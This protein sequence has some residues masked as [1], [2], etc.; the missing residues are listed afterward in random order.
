MIAPLIGKKRSRKLAGAPSLVF[1]TQTIDVVYTGSL[2]MDAYAPPRLSHTTI[3]HI[4]GGGWTS[5][6]STGLGQTKATPANR[7]IVYSL[8]QHG[9]CVFD[10]DYTLVPT[11]T[12]NLNTSYRD[13]MLSNIASAMTYIR[14]NAG[15]FNGDPL[16]ICMVGESAGGHLALMA[17][18]NG[19]N[20]TTRPESVWAGSAFTRLDQ[21]GNDATIKNLLGIA[22]DPSVAGAA[23]AQGYSPYNAVPVN[24]PT[25]CRLTTFSTDLAGVRV[26]DT[27]DFV[28]K[29]NSTGGNAIAVSVTGS[30]HALFTGYQEFE[31]AIA[32]I[33]RN[34]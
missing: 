18:I 4:H 26:A 15:I 19:T 20:G 12:G 22:A 7:N 11:L 34:T 28:T 17:A 10:M 1:P 31:D 5:D 30:S 2:K 23:T 9:F 8:V 13:T 29:V 6:T 3:L 25:P 24:F 33:K 14:A 32:W 27:T 16:H 21:Y